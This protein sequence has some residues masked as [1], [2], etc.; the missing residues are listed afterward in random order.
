[1]KISE[2]CI[3]DLVHAFRL[4]YEL[5]EQRKPL[6]VLVVAGYNDLLRNNSRSFIMEGL[7]HLSELV[8]NLGK[9]DQLGHVNTYA[10]ASLMYP[11]LLTWFPDNGVEPHN[12]DNKLE[13]INWLNSQIHQLNVTNSAPDYPRFH[14]YG[15]RTATRS[16][17]DMYGYEHQSHI[18]SH[19]WEH[20][21]E[22]RRTSKLN[23][24]PERKF[25]MATAINNYFALNTP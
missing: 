23:L 16:K 15:V 8:L 18:K 20:W 22:G 6:D 11:P 21:E 7:R 19:R 10:V 2:G 13:K 17:T 14:T 9:R 3:E 4:D 24:R 25:K 5:P 12:F 1:M